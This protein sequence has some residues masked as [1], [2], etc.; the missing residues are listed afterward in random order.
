[1]LLG[2]LM[3]GGLL[4]APSALVRGYFTHRGDKYTLMT[5]VAY[6]V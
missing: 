3:D 5:L 2:L 1:M 6:V 4:K